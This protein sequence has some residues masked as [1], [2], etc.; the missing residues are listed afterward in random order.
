MRHHR[1]ARIEQCTQ[2][3]RVEVGDTKLTDLADA[4]ELCQMT[5]RLEPSGDVEVPPVELH[6]I[7]RIHPQPRE[8]AIDQSLDIGTREG[9]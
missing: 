5:G 9:G 3:R 8:G 7:E 4:R 1:D 6:Q 2:A